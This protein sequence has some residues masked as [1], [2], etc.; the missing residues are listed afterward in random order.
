MESV[1]E[2]EN[3]PSP[4]ISFTCT[5][6]EGSVLAARDQ[7]RPYYA[8]STMKVAVLLA[9]LRQVASGSLDL[10]APVVATATFTG[11]GAAFTLDGDHLDEQFPVAGTELTVAEVLTPMITRSTNEATNLAMQ[12]V[13]LDAIGQVVSDLGLASTRIERLIGD[14]DAREAGLTN[15]VSSR[16]LTTLTRALL[17]DRFGLGAE[18][19]AFATGLLEAQE[20]PII[21]AVLPAGVRWGSKS[22]WI[23]GIRHDLAFAGEPGAELHLAVCTEGL[24]QQTADQAIGAL[25][26]ALLVPRLAG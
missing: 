21:G 18:L 16:D 8:A 9:A 12:L 22:G 3:H 26:Q 20:L 23:D 25:A 15:E 24:D 13:G 5:D 7:D 11:H 6:A 4:R 10:A 14:V 17:T 2:P 1:S 19:T